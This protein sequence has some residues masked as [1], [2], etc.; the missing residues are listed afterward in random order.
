MRIIFI[1]HGDPNYELDTLTER[2]WKE[3]K[4]LAERVK[5]W[6]VDEFYVSPLGR[7][8]DTASVSLEAMGRQ[9]TTLDFM[10][11]FFVD[12]ADPAT[13]ER[14]I[15][16]DFMPSYWTG[17][18]ELF[19]RDL[20]L[21]SDVMQTGKVEEE[22]R[23]VCDG[24]DGILA[25]HGYRRAGGYYKVENANRKTLVFFC[26]LG[27]QFVILSHLF[28]VSAPVMWQNFFVAPTSVTELVT[29]EREKGIAV[30]RCKRLGDVSHLEAVGIAPSDSGFFNEI[31]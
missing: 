28:G 1:R 21:E 17:K 9:A 18:S 29:E 5:K 13:G 26:H 30:F 8:Q 14:R 2:G 7:A 24:F 3:A 6:Q 20:W 19:E 23:R 31:Y 27:V 25:R 10:R 12:V 16:W 22:Y 4:A 11:E 15:P